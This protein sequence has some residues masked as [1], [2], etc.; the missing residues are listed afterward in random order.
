MWRFVDALALNWLIAGTDAHAKNYSLLLAGSQVRLAPLYDVA[1][2][3]PY[4][5][6]VLGQE[7]AMK[8]GGE[9]RL[10]VIGA[11]N[12]QN[13]ASTSR[14]S[15]QGCEILRAAARCARRRQPCAV[16]ARPT[17]LA[18]GATDRSGRRSLRLVRPAAVTSIVSA[19][20][21]R[22]RRDA[23]LR[24]ARSRMWRSSC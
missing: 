11:R 19:T 13:W 10:K 1:S 22:P 14:S 17:Q 20:S 5:I 16:G 12:W 9:Y 18:A 8:I 21:A 7:L 3:L 24:A 4:D 23:A 2:I 6:D 15:S